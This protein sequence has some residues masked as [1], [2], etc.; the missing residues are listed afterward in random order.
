MKLGYT[1][2]LVGSSDP[3]SVSEVPVP[4]GL[5]RQAGEFSA[6]AGW[7]GMQAGA[8]PLCPGDLGFKSGSPGVQTL[9]KS[10]GYYFPLMKGP[11]RFVILLLSS[12]LSLAS[13]TPKWQSAL[14]FS[15]TLSIHLKPS[16]FPEG[17]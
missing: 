17:S 1:S 4:P 2:V 9:A 5:M 13:C 10:R 7:K 11:T 14:D 12:C 15:M 16:V 3:W 6:A 8:T